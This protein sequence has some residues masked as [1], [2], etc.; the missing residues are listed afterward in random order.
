METQETTSRCQEPQ[1]DIVKDICEECDRQGL[2]LTTQ[3]AYVLA[4]V[5][6][7]TGGTFKPVREAPSK[8]EEWR[9]RNLRYWPYYGRGYI[10]LTWKAN[11]EKYGKILGLDLVND[12]DLALDPKVALFILIHVFK[13]GTLTGRRLEEFVNPDKTD[14]VNARRVINA[15]D[16]AKTIA[17]LAQKWLTRLTSGRPKED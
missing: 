7:E 15:L 16:R 8:S 3:K 2:P 12:P 10:Q 14:F 17:K 5:E 13:N 6:W 11:Y 9:R 4:T 1:T